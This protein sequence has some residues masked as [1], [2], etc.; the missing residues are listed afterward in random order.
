M[1][2]T[3]I[4]DQRYGTHTARFGGSTRLLQSYFVVAQIVCGIAQIMMMCTMI[5]SNHAVTW[6]IIHSET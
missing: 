2:G 3:W 5:I 6:E 1:S 4:F